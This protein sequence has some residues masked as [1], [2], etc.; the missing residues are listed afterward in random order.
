MAD[1]PLRS[2]AATSSWPAPSSPPSWPATCWPASWPPTSWPPSWDR[3]TRACG[4]R[5]TCRSKPSSRPTSWP[6]PTSSPPTS[7]P[8]PTSSRPSWPGRLLRGRLLGRS[9]LLRRRLLGRSRLLR[10]L[11]GRSRLA[12]RLLRRR[13]LHAPQ[14]DG[15]FATASAASRTAAVARSGVLDH[16]NGPAGC[17]AHGVGG[18]ADRGLRPRRA[19]LREVAGTAR[20]RLEL[21]TRAERR[22]ARRGDVHPGAGR[23]VACGAGGAVTTLEDAEAGDRNLLATRDRGVHAVDHRVERSCCA[24][25]VAVET[26]SEH[27][28]EL[29]L[30]W[31]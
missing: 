16:G 28:D 3:S 27:L 18:L 6:E 11:L 30:V 12:R 29:S 24:L 22:H 14:R 21:R 25:P 13:L 8:E 26:L 7:W 15:R 23:G 9:R 2:G 1:A 19:F 20:D 10:R 4:R 31:H 17:V 5:R